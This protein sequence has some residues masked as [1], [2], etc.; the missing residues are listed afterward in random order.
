LGFFVINLVPNGEHLHNLATL[1][2]SNP[3]FSLPAKTTVDIRCRVKAVETPLLLILRKL[4]DD[5]TSV[6][7]REQTCPGVNVMIS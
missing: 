7:L 2:N 5:D 1:L 4:A 6:S 3:V